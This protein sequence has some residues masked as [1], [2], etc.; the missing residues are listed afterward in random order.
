MKFHRSRFYKG[1]PGFTVSSDDLLL[2]A[3]EASIYRWWWEFMRLSPVFWYARTTGLEPVIPEIAGAYAAAGKLS[4]PSFATWWDKHGKYVF[5]ETNRPASARLV[6]IDGRAEHELYQKSILVEIP[7]TITN[8]KIIR[9]IKQ[10]LAGVEHQM[11]ATTVIGQSNAALRLKSKK[12]NLTTIE[13]EFW[14]LVY[15]ILHPKI[16]LW[17]IGD[18][19]QIAPNNRVRGLEPADVAAEYSRGLGPFARLQS[20]VGRSYYKARFARHNVERGSFPNYSKVADDPKLMPFGERHH[21]DFLAATDETSLQNSPWQQY[22]REEHERDLHYR[23]MQANRLDRL[24][25]RDSTVKA[26]IPA[27]VAGDVDL[28][29]P[30]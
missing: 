1:I 22:I 10:I 15:R 24:V 29:S 2:T 26:K 17:K 13:N 6:D 11:T 8:K 14:V 30:R 3:A 18:R 4:W 5:E 28:Q 12:Y 21:A 7:L 23:I 16:P 19:L 9:D 20:L 25:I 27:F